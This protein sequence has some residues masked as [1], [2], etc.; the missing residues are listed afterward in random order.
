MRNKLFVYILLFTFAVSCK[1]PCD[2]IACLNGGMCDNGNCL[3]PNWYEGEFCESEQ[4]TKF[5]GNYTGTFTVNY[6]ITA[7]QDVQ[8]GSLSFSESPQGIEY[9]TSSFNTNST[10]KLTTNSSPNI[11]LNPISTT[12]GQFN[13]TTTGQGAFK[14]DSVVINFTYYNNTLNSVSAT[15]VFKGVK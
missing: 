14:G 1:N 5:F 3:C 8:N 9:L 6:V 12:A 7:V 10:F 11:E 15:G 4:R 2:T 13:I